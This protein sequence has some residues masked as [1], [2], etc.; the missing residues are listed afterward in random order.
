[1]WFFLSW[2]QEKPHELAHYRCE[3]DL[4]DVKDL[5]LELRMSNWG[6]WCQ[7]TFLDIKQGHIISCQ[8][9]IIKMENNKRCEIFLAESFA[10]FVDQT[11]SVCF[12]L[13]MTH[14]AQISK[15]KLV[16]TRREMKKVPF[17]W[18]WF[19][20]YNFHS[21]HHIYPREKPRTVY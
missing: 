6:P 8:N 2:Y 4:L 9:M 10:I 15:K 12:G 1:M 16:R 11:V 21:P 19:L 14:D 20:Q 5:S 18:L 13:S 7:A 3:G 17:S